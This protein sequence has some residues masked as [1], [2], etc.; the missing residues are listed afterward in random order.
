MKRVEKDIDTLSLKAKEKI[1]NDLKQGE[2]IELFKKS[3]KT[4]TYKPV[5]VKA[6]TLDQQLA[7]T[8]SS[9]E[10]DFIK[11][12]ILDI[13]KV[14]SN[15]TVSSY[16]RNKALTQVDITK[17]EEA[18]LD[19]LKKLS[20]K[21]YDEKELTKAKRRYL[22]LLDDI[23]DITDD[24]TEEDSENRIL[25]TNKLREIDSKLEEL[26]KATPQRSYRLSGRTTFNEANLI[27]W[28]AA[29]LSLTIADYVRFAIFDYEPNTFA[30]RHLSVNA[31]KRFY[32][33]ILDVAKNGWG[34]P[35]AVNECPNCARYIKDIII[36]K[37]QL[38]RYK[39]VEKARQF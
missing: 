34:A 4:S 25:Y 11:R 29:R 31:R 21:E 32:V 26:K 13:K 8:I 36:L 18:A 1:L 6:L 2:L 24:E 23:I 38:A 37:E 39:A 12:D 22:K 15:I 17:W 19:G 10:K 9:N 3:C 35:P 7:I 16:I 20:S 33:S 28:R 27:R 14:S 30:D 5:T